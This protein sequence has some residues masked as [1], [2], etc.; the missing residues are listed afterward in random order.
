[1]PEVLLTTDQVD[2]IGTPSLQDTSIEGVLS[3]RAELTVGPQ[4]QRGSRIF[5][6]EGNPNLVNIGQDP[7]P[8]DMYINLLS[9]DLEYLYLYQYFSSDGQNQWNRLLR[10]IPNTFLTTQER[11]F[12]EGR[13]IF[14]VPIINVVPL[15]EVGNITSQNFNIQHN[16]LN[17]SPIASSVTVS[18]LIIQ[19]DQLVLPVSINAAEYDG[20]NW[21]SINGQRTV[22]LL[23]TIA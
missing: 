8:F 19:S 17:D 3:K 6:G 12:S 18:D 9:S 13:T 10:L 4:G 15:S 21:S 2:V 1:M 5:V 16:V 14:F 23:V 11:T 22:Q 20:T 7:L